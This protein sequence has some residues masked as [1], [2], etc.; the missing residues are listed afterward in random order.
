ML[1]GPRLF[2]L[3]TGEIVV[4]ITLCNNVEREKVEEKRNTSNC[5]QERIKDVEMQI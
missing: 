3:I 4:Q 1:F 5:N 2:G